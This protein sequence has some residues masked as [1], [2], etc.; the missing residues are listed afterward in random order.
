ML[1]RKVASDGLSHY[2]YFLADGGEAVVIDPRRDIDEY[3]DLAARSRLRIRYVLETHRNEDYVTGSTALRQATGAEILHSARRAHHY[4]SGI[5]EGHEIGF[6]TLRLRAM[7][8]PGH[9]LE[10]LSFLLGDRSTGDRPFAVF[11]GDALF[12]GD[13][14]RTDLLGDDR[15]EELAAHLY[16]TLHQSILPLGDGV[17]LFAAHGGGSVCGGRISDREITSVGFERQTNPLLRQGRQEFIRSKAEESPLKAPYFKRM[18]EWNARGNAPV[19]EVLPVLRPLSP[20]EFE[21]MSES[22]RTIVDLRMPQAFAGGHIPG[23]YNVWM[24]GIAGYL[25]WVVGPG[26]RLILVIPEQAALDAVVRQLLRI[27]YDEIDGYLAGGFEAWQNSGRDFGS[28]ATVG[29]RTVERL[30]ETQGA[31]ILDV[32]KPEEWKSGSIPGARRIFVGHLE[33]RLSEVPSERPVI[34]TCSVGHRGGVAASI[35]ARNGYRNVANYLGGI[36]AWQA[37]VPATGPMT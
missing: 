10:S 36:A 37:R 25:G 4:G 15:K 9:T 11:T 5:G 35:L 33:S 23:S 28:F 31:E 19:Y 13:V 32:R 12:A 30:V 14:G 6:G 16:D 26:T 22:G 2:S 7:E 34:A 17:V 21:E 3:L 18:E 29:T 20:D 27:G 24:E 8:T 1:F